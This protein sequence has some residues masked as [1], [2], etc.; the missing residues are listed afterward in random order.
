ML[1]KRKLFNSILP[2]QKVVDH[3]DALRLGKM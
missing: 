1:S 3:L 2:E